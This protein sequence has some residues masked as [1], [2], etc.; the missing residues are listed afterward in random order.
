MIKKCYKCASFKTRQGTGITG[1]CRFNPPMYVAYN[2]NVWP[3]VDSDEWC[4]GF[5]LNRDKYNDDGRKI[6][7]KKNTRTIR[8]K[9]QL[10]A[11]HNGDDDWYQRPGDPDW[12][13]S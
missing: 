3:E 9:E 7:T 5:Q 12:G 6:Y 10:D 11:Y 2:K 1:E 4:S 13:K 8:S